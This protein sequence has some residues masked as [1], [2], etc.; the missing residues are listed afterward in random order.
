MSRRRSPVN[1][2]F[3]TVSVMG[4]FA[5]LS[6]TMSK[7]P[8]LKPFATYLGTPHEL[9]GIVAA[10]S[11][12]PGILVSLP[13]ASL[14]DFFGRRKFLLIAGFVFASAPFLYVFVTIWWQ[15]ILV[16]F[17][18]GFAT[19]IFVPVAE[20]SI[21][22]LFPQKRAERISLFSSVAYVGRIVA[23]SLG[24]YILFATLSNFRALYLAVGV[25]G[26]TALIVA[27]AFIAE[28][29]KPNL[30]GEDPEPRTIL[31][32]LYHGWGA[33]ATSRAAL[34]VSLVQAAQFYAFGVVEFFLAGYLPEIA[35]IDELF[36]GIILS[37]MVFMTVI[38]KPWI[39]RISD[40]TGRR[41]PI[42]IGCVVSGLPLLIVPFVTNFWI[43]LALMI[44]YGLGFAAVT[45]STS[46]LMS[47]VVPQQL[48]GTSMGFLDT[49]MDV[50][51]TLGPIV[52]GLIFASYLHYTGVF[53]SLT[54]IL[55]SASVVF[56]VTMAGKTAKADGKRPED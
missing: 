40:K 9:I 37:S 41:M 31:K 55:V 53:T 14:S 6:S 8:V 12:I 49:I 18:H 33:V 25:V 52:S 11:T 15:L 5:I 46:A 51:Q 1:T 17:Y 38:V 30:A 27:L 20:A 42:I 16:R 44:A 19:A 4:F 50:G 35:Q 24:G 39:G 32:G 10:A 36:T 26:V 23:P 21:A 22:E 7:S 54:L 48:L 43:L 28:L 34:S 47:E 3:L 29:R 13:A 45:S 56:A 2:I